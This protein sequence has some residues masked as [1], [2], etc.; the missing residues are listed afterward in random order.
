MKKRG[1]NFPGEMHSTEGAQ[2]HTIFK[3]LQFSLLKE[4]DQQLQGMHFYN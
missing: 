2:I 4:S 3:N 1:K